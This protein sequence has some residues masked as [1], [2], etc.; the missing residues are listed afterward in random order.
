MPIYTDVHFIV[1]LLALSKDISFEDAASDAIKKDMFL[2]PENM[3]DIFFVEDYQF[4][5]FEK[6]D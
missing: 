5:K 6:F 3:T 1:Q 4:V 2:E